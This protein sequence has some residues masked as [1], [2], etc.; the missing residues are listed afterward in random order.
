MRVETA[1]NANRSAESRLTSSKTANC[2]SE[3]LAPGLYLQMAAPTPSGGRAIAPLLYTTA[4]SIPTYV[5]MCNFGDYPMSRLTI[6]ITDQQHQSL[7]ALAALHG[8]TI[9]EILNEELAEG[10]ACLATFSLRR[11]GAHGS[12]DTTIGATPAC[13][14]SVSPASTAHVA[15]HARPAPWVKVV[16]THRAQSTPTPQTH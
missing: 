15:H 4:C 3:E 11:D 6:D 5:G 13:T 2:F 12:D 1:Y 9:N 14:S 10:R 7:K 8:K 16:A